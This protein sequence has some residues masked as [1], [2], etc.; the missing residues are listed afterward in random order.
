MPRHQAPLLTN[1]ASRLT[2]K[3]SRDLY[4]GLQTRTSLSGG[5]L[6]QRLVRHY[7]LLTDDLRGSIFGANFIA[8]KLRIEWQDREQ[9]LNYASSDCE[10]IYVI[11]CGV[12]KNPTRSLDSMVES[13]ILRWQ[14]ES[15]SPCTSKGS[16]QAIVGVTGHQ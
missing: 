5:A 11:S 16:F 3:F 10:T 15:P 9:D 7:R 1:A 2:L 6:L 8:N 4:R 13:Q 14:R 12:V